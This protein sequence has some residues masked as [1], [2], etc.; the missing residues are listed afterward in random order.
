MWEAIPIE[1]LAMFFKLYIGKCPSSFLNDLKDQIFVGIFYVDARM[2]ITSKSIIFGLA[3]EYHDE[4][5]V[6]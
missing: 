4:F 3:K 1:Y 6:G 5:L 2:L